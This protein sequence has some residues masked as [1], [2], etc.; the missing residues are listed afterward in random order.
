MRRI[1]TL[2]RL[3]QSE[4]PMETRFMRALMSRKLNATELQLVLALVDLTWA[5]GKTF[6]QV[7]L[8]VLADKLSTTRVTVA[9]SV[10]RLVG[11]GIVRVRSAG[12]GNR[13]GKIYELVKDPS[14]WRTPIKV[15]ELK[16][17]NFGGITIRAGSADATIGSG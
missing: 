13:R 11:Y 6:V 9:H 2:R 10:K 16:V 5:L 4:T 15:P 1:K 7:T 17:R 3:R 12:P 8:L 14:L